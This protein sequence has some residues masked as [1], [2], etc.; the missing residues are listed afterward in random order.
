MKRAS[1]GSG[2]INEPAPVPI[3]SLLFYIKYSEDTLKGEKTDLPLF[4]FN[5]K[6]NNITLNFTRSY[7]SWG[8]DI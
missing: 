8:E 7:S 3:P 5:L 4:K 6:E 2:R 1:G